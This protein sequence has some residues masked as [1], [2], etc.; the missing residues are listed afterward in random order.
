[1]RRFTAPREFAALREIAALREAIAAPRALSGAIACGGHPASPQGLRAARCLWISRIAR[2]RMLDSNIASLFDESF[3]SPRR[4]G[5]LGRSSTGDVAAVSGVCDDERGFLIRQSFPAVPRLLRFGDAGQAP[6]AGSR[7]IRIQSFARPMVSPK[8]VKTS[9]SV[10]A[11]V[12]C[13]AKLCG[14]LATAH[15]ALTTFVF[16]RHGGRSSERDVRDRSDT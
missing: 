8:F 3:R 4:R 12:S 10:H 15:G 13:F 14:R 6:R 7:S 9:R 5:C 16:G 2:R 11:R 1:V